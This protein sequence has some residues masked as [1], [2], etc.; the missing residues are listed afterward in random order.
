MSSF[1]KTDRIGVGVFATLVFIAVVAVVVWGIL[2]ATGMWESSQV[3]WFA[4]CF[5]CP[6]L[7]LRYYV[8]RG[9]T[10][11]VKGIATTLFVTFVVFLFVF[12][13]LK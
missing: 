7:L 3:R 4:F 5:V 9:M 12:L 1:F 8:R 10:N 13:K 2:M 11:V 6:A